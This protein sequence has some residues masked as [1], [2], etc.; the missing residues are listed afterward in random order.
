MSLELNKQKAINVTIVGTI[1]DVVLS[2]GKIIVGTV[3]FSHSLIIDGIHSLSDLLTDL[4]VLIVANFSH[5]H[6]DDEH[7]YGHGRFET[8]GTIVIGI[9][10]VVVA[11]FLA[12]D[13]I[14]LFL[15]GTVKEIPKWPTLVVAFISII[16]KEWLFR[17]SL[18]IGEEIKSQLIIANAWHS[19]SDALSSILVFVGL[20]F[21]LYGY[22]EVDLVVAVILSLFIGKVGW[23]F[24]LNSL[25]ELLDTSVSE[26]M[27]EE[28]KAIIKSIDGVKG[29]HNLRSRKIGDKAILDVNIEVAPNITVSEGHEI[30]TWTAET[31]IK[32]FDSVYDV[33]VHTD[34]EDDR[35]TG[36]EYV[37]YESKLLPL[38]TEVLE[39]LEKIIGTAEYSKID[40]VKIHY[41]YKRIKL[42]LLYLGDKLPE[43]KVILDAI[44]SDDLFE[45][46]VF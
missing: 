8:L 23:D 40:E 18:K 45:E 5:D 4:F 6:P 32:A 13:N 42:S 27:R 38:R 14:S 31:V 10:L 1:V 28:I 29:M 33:T 25:H 16:S 19:R 46:V 11:I 2:A 26:E 36:Q 17:Y 34:V 12:I 43:K 41:R 15:A 24:I 3:F 39:K 7:P 20:I 37:V 30:A 9:V 22:K 21:S 35:E 44:E